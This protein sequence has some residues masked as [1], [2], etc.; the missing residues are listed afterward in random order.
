MDLDV[1]QANHHGAENGSLQAFLQDMSPTVIVIS[2]GSNRTYDHPRQSTLNRMQGL[3]PAP[4]IFQL[5]KY[6]GGDAQGG[7]VPDAFIAD[8]QTTETDGTITLTVDAAAGTY[9][10]TYGTQSHPFTI[11]ARP[12]ADVVIEALL[13][14]PTSAAD[15][16][17]E[18][19]GDTAQQ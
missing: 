18:T 15:R 6:L 8:P 14:D 7:N 5:N 2:N 19:N 3:S 11:K 10:M 12:T 13:P 1:Y 17:A 9:V 4:R 16:I